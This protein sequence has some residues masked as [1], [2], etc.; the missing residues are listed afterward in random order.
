MNGRFPATAIARI[1]THSAVGVHS[2]ISTTEPIARTWFDS[3]RQV[4]TMN[5]LRY[6]G[7]EPWR[8]RLENRV[9]PANVGNRPL[10]ASM[11]H[12]RRL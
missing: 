11:C 5:W 10:H 7:S 1:T 2:F 6:S 8:L 12:T 9:A 3:P 4:S